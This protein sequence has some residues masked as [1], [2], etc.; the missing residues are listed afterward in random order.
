MSQRAVTAGGR[1]GLARDGPRCPWLLQ[2]AGASEGH[3]GPLGVL[4]ARLSA[5]RS[6]RSARNAHASWKSL[7][8]WA[9]EWLLRRERALFRLSMPVTVFKAA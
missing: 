3:T 8:V 1:C 6:R 2:P 4:G 5:R 7:R 9:E